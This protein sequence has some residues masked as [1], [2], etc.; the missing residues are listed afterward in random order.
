MADEAKLC[1]PIRSTFEVLCNMWLGVVKNWAHSVDQYWLAGVAVSSASRRF[2]E[3][4]SQIQR[5]HQAS[6]S[7]SGSPNSDH[8]YFWCK[9][10]LGSVLHFLLSPTTD[11]VITGCHVKSTFHRTSQSDQE[12]VRCCIE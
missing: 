6:E 5:F 9:S 3:H 8:E 4:T 7:C 12:I 1:S 11:L 2:A 10:A